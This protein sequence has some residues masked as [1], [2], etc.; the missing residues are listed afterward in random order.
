MPCQTCTVPSARYSEAGATELLA[1]ELP[2]AVSPPPRVG[3]RRSWSSLPR[4]YPLKHRAAVLLLLYISPP[5]AE[6]SLAE[7]N[8]CCSLYC[9]SQSIASSS[10]TLSRTPRTLHHLS[11]RRNWPRRRFLLRGRQKRRRTWSGRSAT[12]PAKPTPPLASSR[13]SRVHRS[14][15]LVSTVSDALERRLA[16][17]LCR[18]ARLRRGHTF[19]FRLRPSQC[20]HHASVSLPHLPRPSSG[21]IVAVSGGSS[22]RRRVQA[23]PSR[24]GCR[25]PC[26]VVHPLARCFDLL[27]S[28]SHEEACGAARAAVG[29]ATGE[30]AGRRAVPSLFEREREEEGRG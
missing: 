22:V 19:P 29:L 18:R 17:S 6:L 2:W 7:K 15:R 25:S 30:I 23:R 27:R 13:H 21:S 26:S 9:S 16:A 11:L 24:H 12:P 5:P 10:I 28:S 20:K 3:R 8:L 4:L 1:D 14:G